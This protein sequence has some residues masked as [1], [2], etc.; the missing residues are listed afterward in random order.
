MHENEAAH[1]GLS[2][3]YTLIDLQALSLGPE[4]LGDLIAWAEASGFAGLNIT[5]PCKQAATAFVDSLS[6]AA[7]IGAINTVVFEDG[8][9]IGHNTDCSGF[10]ASFTED[11]AGVKTDAVILLGAGGAGSAVGHALLRCGVASLAIHD[12]DHARADR[13]ADALVRRFGPGTAH[14]VSELSEP[15]SVCD[16]LVNATPIGTDEHPGMPLDA[17]LLRPDLWV[18]DIIYFTIETDLLSC[19]RRIGCR[20]ISGR[21]M[22]VYQAAH[23]FALFTGRT[24]DVARMRSFF[25]AAGTGE[26][27]N[28]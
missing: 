16:G 11:L 4:A 2:L 9:R 26:R 12:V 5:H 25:D 21:G 3:T 14:A 13:L 1:Q 18:V 27:D 8:Q 28:E 17:A 23:A 19:A 24:P 7:A 6:D 15:L 20:T 10:A 22:A